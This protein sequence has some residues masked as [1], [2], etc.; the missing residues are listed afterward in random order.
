MA[1]QRAK[2]V[3]AEET[4]PEPPAEVKEIT[5]AQATEA[6]A[7]ARADNVR[8]ILAAGADQI[9][10]ILQV[11]HARKDWAALGHASFAE[12]VLAEYHGWL[13]RFES[14]PQRT[15]V[16][17]ELVAAGIPQRDVGAMTGTSG[18][19]VNRA[20]NPPHV[21]DETP[22]QDDEPEQQ[23]PTTRKSAANKE[24]ELEESLERIGRL[25]QAE[26]DSILR[27]MHALADAGTTRCVP[28]RSWRGCA[29]MVTR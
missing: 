20:V 23:Q 27:A 13:P 25:A 2:K 3:T 10:P 9:L 12:Y 14:I 7:T 21:P 18:A 19:T 26:E 1:E 11:A 6:E 4:A 8:E 15:E 28:P 24:K 16:I 5:L 29:S 17:K 22:D